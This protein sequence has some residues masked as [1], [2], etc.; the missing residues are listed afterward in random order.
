MD[1]NIDVCCQ[2]PA[3][4]YLTEANFAFGFHGN[5]KPTYRPAY[6]GVVLHWGSQ[7]QRGLKAWTVGSWVRITL[8]AW[9]FVYVYSVF[10]LGSGLATGWSTVQGVL[11][12]LYRVRK[13]SETKRLTDALCSWGSNRN[14]NEWMYYVTFTSWSTGERKHS[15]LHY[16]L[17]ALLYVFTYTLRV[18]VSPG[19][20]NK[21]RAIPVTGRGGQ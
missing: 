21:G 1:W 4:S 16:V 11:P 9:R 18:H 10:V 7:W 14:M 6:I 19:T 15:V 12:T 13:W 20:V 2:L 5:D 17:R 3:V 8:E